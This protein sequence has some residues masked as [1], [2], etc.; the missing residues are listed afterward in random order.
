VD[1]PQDIQIHSTTKLT[2]HI[3]LV[4]LVFGE[5]IILEG[6]SDFGAET[7]G[8]G[9]PAGNFRRDELIPVCAKRHTCKHFRRNRFVSGG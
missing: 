7:G 8:V 2:H 6:S 9:S 3:F 5:I 1:A 4:S